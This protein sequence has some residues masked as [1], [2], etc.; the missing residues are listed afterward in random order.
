[1]WNQDFYPGGLLC[2][3]RLG[4]HLDRYRTRERNPWVLEPRDLTPYLLLSPDL[5][6]GT[7]RK[8][9]SQCR[10]PTGLGSG[11]LPGTYR[12]RLVQTTIFLGSKPLPPKRYETVRSVGLREHRTSQWYYGLDT[13]ILGRAECLRDCRWSF[14][15]PQ[16]KPSWGSLRLRTSRVTNYN[17]TD[18]GE[19]SRGSGRRR[20]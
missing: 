15:F 16:E 8:S 19:R 4:E 12:P 3:S 1:M 2:G 7:L 20:V 10:S 6:H 13:H 18:T 5:N 9:T 11:I 14:G 17:V